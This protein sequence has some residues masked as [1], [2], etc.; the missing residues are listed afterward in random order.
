VVERLRKAPHA[1]VEANGAGAIDATTYHLPKED[2]RIIVTRADGTSLYV[3][4]DVAYHLA[5]LARFPRV[6][7]V[8][9]QDHLLH[10]KTLLALLTELGEARAPEFVLYQY[11]VLP[12]GGK[13]STRQGTAVFLDDLL[14]EAVERARKEILARR[15]DLGADEVESIAA[16]LGGS[17]VRYHIVRVAPDK[18]VRFAW[19]DALSFEGRSGPFAQYSYARAS[20]ILRKAGST[21]TAWTGRASEVASAP[22]RALVRTISRFPGLVAYAARTAHVHTIAGYAHDLAETFNR[23]YQDVPV[24]R[25][26]VERE[27]RLALVQAARQTLGNTLELLGLDRLEAM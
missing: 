12:D 16:K 4:R 1:V 18:A 7:D 21:P 10:A 20:S 19:E 22:E 23:F 9:G 13:M 25:A 6:I 14:D 17:A 8:L 5:K 15:E 2:A 3:T 27:S 11:V 24:L 26:E